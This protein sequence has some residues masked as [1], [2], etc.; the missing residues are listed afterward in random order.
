[1]L[2]PNHPAMIRSAGVIVLRLTQ[3]SF[4]DSIG[5]LLPDGNRPRPF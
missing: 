2:S 4:Y 1:M 5:A 3:I